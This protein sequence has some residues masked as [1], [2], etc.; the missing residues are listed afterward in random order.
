[1]DKFR[2]ILSPKAVKDLDSFSDILCERIAT[3]MKVLENNPFPRGKGIKKIKGTK[4]VFYRLRI[5]KYRV[6]YTIEA[7]RVV[8]LRFLS[9]KDA[10][11]FIQTLN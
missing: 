7:D 3:N 1:V 8:I 10:E 4:S 6:F 9:K 2:I 11:R 5:D